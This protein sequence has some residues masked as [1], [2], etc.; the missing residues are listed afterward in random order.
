MVLPSFLHNTDATLQK[1]RSKVI[2]SVSKTYIKVWCKGGV[3]RFQNQQC[4]HMFIDTLWKMRVLYYQN[5]TS[6]ST[7]IL[8][9]INATSMLDETAKIY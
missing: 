8:D 5:E 1:K 3:L 6:R 7:V 4:L 2:Q 9:T